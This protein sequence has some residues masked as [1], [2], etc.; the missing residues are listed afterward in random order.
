MVLGGFI[1]GIIALVLPP[2]PV[3]IRRGCSGHVLLNIFLCLLGW[4][5]GVVHAWYIIL[6][7]PSLR[8]RSQQRR[9]RRRNSTS[10]NVIVREEIYVPPRQG[11][12]RTS[13]SRSRSRTRS[14]SSVGRIAAAPPPAVDVYGGS[15]VPYY[16]EEV[17]A[18][19]GR[20]GYAPP[21][22]VKY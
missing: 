22:R 3:I 5:P 1:L 2:L 10:S 15:R 14:R 4:I 20:G 7:T 16:R 9:R 21:P 18:Y 11:Y 13:R 6:E 12:V 17:Y 19:D 8:Q